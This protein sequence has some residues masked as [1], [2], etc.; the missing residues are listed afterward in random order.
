MWKA[1]CMPRMN[2]KWIV[3][4]VTMRTVRA[5]TSCKPSCSWNSKSLL[6]KVWVIWQPWNPHP[7]KALLS[8]QE[9]TSKIRRGDSL[10]LSAEID[11]RHS[12]RLWGSLLHTSGPLDTDFASWRTA[13]WKRWNPGH[14]K[15]RTKDILG[16]KALKKPQFLCWS[17][18][19]CLCVHFEDTNN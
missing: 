9:G 7:K 17:E 3:R 13:E 14:A 1:Q 12:A 15:Q 18:I 8:E 5:P 19:V 16:Q 10:Q 4:K 11:G 2:R 6:E